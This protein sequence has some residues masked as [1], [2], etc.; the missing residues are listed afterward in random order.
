MV[1][2]V[3]WAISKIA[4]DSPDQPTLS[5]RKSRLVGMG[6]RVMWVITG[7]PVSSDR[8]LLLCKSD[9]GG[10]GESWLLHLTVMSDKGH[11]VKLSVSQ[12]KGLNGRSDAPPPPA[13]VGYSP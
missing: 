9:G 10:Q 12:M 7:K 11:Y 5:F 2:S 3:R 1:R 4:V 6:V 13:I 8:P